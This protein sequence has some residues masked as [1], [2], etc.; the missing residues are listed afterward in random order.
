MFMTCSQKIIVQ[1]SNL[2]NL[3][4]MIFNLEKLYSTVQLDISR[5]EL[6]LI[7]VYKYSNFDLIFI[8]LIILKIFLKLPK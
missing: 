2:F 3:D 6:I 8:V 5:V 1:F 7:I 4:F